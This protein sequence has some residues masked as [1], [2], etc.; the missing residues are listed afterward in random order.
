MI[1]LLAPCG[2]FES[3]VGSINSGCDA[4]YLGGENFNA[5][6]NAKNF[7]AEEIKEIVKISRKL[8]VSVY[9]T[10][11]T[12]YK[13][14]EYPKLIEFLD[15]MYLCGISAFI[16]QDL[17]L[18]N[19]IKAR[20]KD[21]EIHGSTQLSA[22][23]LEDVLFF[24]E[25]GFNRIV[26]NREMSLADIK[27]ISENSTIDLEV[28]A[29]GALCVSFS[30]QCLMS[31][32]IGE[33]SGNRGTCSQSCRLSYNLSDD[34]KIYKKGFLLS[35]KDITSIKTLDVLKKYCTSL[36]IEGRM[37]NSTYVTNTVSI[38]REKLDGTAR[39]DQEL[40]FDLTK[41]FNRGGSLSDG[42]F[43]SHSSENMMSIETPKSTG[44]LIGRINKI[45]KNGTI[46]FISS[47]NLISGDGIYVLN[48]KNERIG[49]YI[50]KNSDAGFVQ[51]KLKGN[52]QSN[53]PIYKSF[54]KKLFDDTK[55][56]YSSITRKSKV[57]ARVNC[58]LGEKIS[59]ELIKEPY[60]IKVFGDILEKS[61]NNP[62]TKETLISKLSKAGNS[63]YEFEFDKIQLEDNLFVP[64]SS[65][66]D[67]KNMAIKALDEKIELI[68]RSIGNHSNVK[69]LSNI[70]SNL[71]T[72]YLENPEKLEEIYSFPLKR[73][74]IPL[75]KMDFNKKYNPNVYPALPEILETIHYP[76]IID[77]MQKAIA[78]GI[79]GFL[80]STFG[81]INLCK[82]FN[83][84]YVLNYTFNIF[85][86]YSK[87]FF[88]DKII[89]LSP[90]I[91]LKEIE[92]IN[93]TNTEMIIHGHIKVMETRQCPV[94]LYIGNKKNSPFCSQKNKKNN[95]FLLDRLNYKNTLIT[96]CT[97]CTCKI[98]SSNELAFLDTIKDFKTY[99]GDFRINCY[100]S[101][102]LPVLNVYLNEQFNL[103]DGQKYLSHLLKGVE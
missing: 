81:Q 79:Q 16:I 2:D 24:Q 38:F 52:I 34:T 26:L 9:L 5:R 29:H 73:I 59:L 55:K 84:D 25:L 21:I 99:N 60:S 54:D 17:G 10:V 56:Y 4:V 70:K 77:F 23:S 92:E 11:N 43:N 30:G 83:V 35:P 1:E 39:S 89:T 62:L 76:L 64:L 90:E 100:T 93:T 22:H 27:Y 101:N 36:K 14:N 50:N 49:T 57:K 82:N 45:N 40:I 13:E 19:I 33:R 31:S 98:L 46:D 72:L 61:H 15:K 91:T 97:L 66:K 96:N 28:F 103:F 53:N 44:I 48:D 51:I 88:E 3:F 58:K 65:L 41:S 20:Y 32:S 85:N 71:F 12:L 68:N 47:E 37:K 8:N 78:C 7:S 86:S 6:R 18:I 69:K 75:L 87:E 42:Y 80:V 102:P 67:L 74:Y 95:Y 94:G 63:Y